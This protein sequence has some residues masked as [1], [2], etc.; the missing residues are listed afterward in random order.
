MYVRTYLLLE[1]D[2]ELLEALLADELLAQRQLA[3]VLGLLQ[4]QPRRLDVADQ[5][6]LWRHVHALTVGLEARLNVEEVRLDVAALTVPVCACG[7]NL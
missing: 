5:H 4:H 2:R 7:L 3:V 1:L 6:A